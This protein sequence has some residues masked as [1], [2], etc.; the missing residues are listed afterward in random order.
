MAATPL[1]LDTI[2][3][4]CKRRGII[5]PGSEI[6]GGLQG[7]FDYGPV[8]VELKRNVK[9]AWWRCVV[10]ERFDVEGI[11]AA[12]L[13]HPQTWKAS[14]HV[15]GFVDPLCDT[16]RPARKRYRADHIEPMECTA[17]QVIDVTEEPPKEIPGGEIWAPTK[18]RAKEI[19]GQ[20]WEKHLGLEGHRVKLEEVAGSTQVGRFSP[21][22]GGKLTEPRMFNLMLSTVLGPVEETGARVYLRPETAQG[23]FVNF[24][25]V[26]TTAR[27]KLA[28]GIAQQGKSFRNEITPRNFIFRTREFEQ[29]EME[30]FCKPESCCKPGERT[31][32]EWYE[33][34]RDERF[35]WYTRYGIRKENL[36]LRDH[37]SDELAHYARACCDVEYLFPIGWQELEGIAHRG[38]FDLRQHQ[39]HSGRDLRYFDSERNEHYLPCVVEPAAGADRTTLAFL[40][41]AYREEI[42]RKGEEGEDGGKESRRVVLA[43][44]PHLAPIKAAVLPLLQ[45][46]DDLVEMARKLAS[47]LKGSMVATYDDTGGIG[48]LYRRQDEIG[49]PY[50][51]TVDVESLGDGAV[52]IR[53]RDTMAQER[54]AAEKV[55]G[56]LV[57]KMKL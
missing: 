48:K 35:A 21:D 39:E 14:G 46:R 15:D 28:F 7:T 44:H 37:E 33:Y 38:D 53:D 6:Y 25:N 10:Q 34:W 45:N 20:W 22:D 30:F 8:G 23:I 1:T 51:V 31:D 17:F 11:D 5:Y 18:K 13:M 36:R 55:K 47:D 12:L 29:M 4:L 41:D 26:K 3:S 27:R 9:A 43:L 16:L 57:E 52:T 32:M 49:T 56:W 50:C 24:D 2:V 19:Y 42:V 40:C 54:V